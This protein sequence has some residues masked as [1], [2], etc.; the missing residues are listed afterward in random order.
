[1]ATKTKGLRIATPCATV[2]QFIAAFHRFCEESSFFIS[3]LSLRPIGIETAFSVDLSNGQSMLRGFG[4]VLDA[5]PTAANR[6]GRPGV[7]IGVHELTA[8]TKGV[9][10][11]LLI[12]RAIAQSEP[13]ARNSTRQLWA[14]K[15]PEIPTTPPILDPSSLDSV[16]IS[17]DD[18]APATVPNLVPPVIEEPRVPKAR[19]LQTPR[20]IPIIAPVPSAPITSRAPTIVKASPPPPT[21][22]VT[23]TIVKA[24]P[25]PIASIVAKPTP[26]PVPIA[27]VVAKRIA[28]ISSVETPA[29]TRT[30]TPAPIAPART[31]TPP[32]PIAAV[33]PPPMPPVV[34]PIAAQLSEQIDDE[35]NVSTIVKSTRLPSEQIVEDAIVDAA[36]ARPDP[37]D[38]AIVGV[39]LAELDPIDVPPPPIVA[40]PAPAVAVDAPVVVAAP[41]RT[42][43][44]IV[45]IS[46]VFVVGVA[47]GIIV[48]M[49]V[50]Q[51]R[52]PEPSS[53][54]SSTPIVMG[55]SPPIA[56]ADASVANDAEPAV[57]TVTNDAASVAAI[58]ID[59]TT[60]QA[61]PADAPVAG[62]V[63]AAPAVVAEEPPSAPKPKPHATK[64]PPRPYVRPKPKPPGHAKCEG[65]SC[66]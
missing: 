47:V 15:L 32:A 41:R 37:I 7:R 23:P 33:V 21:P 18:N 64:P 26:T 40:V 45:A 46:G 14:L 4:V 12:A 34:A 49:R 42:A 36:P 60:A 5:W 59:A 20:S 10:E 65:L 25:T 55:V 54:L 28:P 63:D 62:I 9:F 51:S 22:A 6:F 52:E 57:A 2:E 29:V 66:I 1:M 11:Q 16:P 3:T 8:D 19:I 43:R 56:P 27:S 13:V 24:S 61:I 50:E 30:P 44:W 48:G 38:D 17:Q 31:S 53:A 35:L 39:V 58:A